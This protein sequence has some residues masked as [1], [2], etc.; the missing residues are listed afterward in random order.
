[1]RALAVILFFVILSGCVRFFADQDTA[2]FDQLSITGYSPV[3]GAIITNTNTVLTWDEVPGAVSYHFKMS[4]D[5]GYEIKSILPTP[6]IYLDSPSYTHPTPLENGISYSW[7]VRA[8]DADGITNNWSSFQSF[9]LQWAPENA[10]HQMSPGN[11]AAV[12]NSNLSFNWNPVNGAVQYEISISAGNTS[13]ADITDTPQYVP[14]SQ[15][16]GENSWKVRPI[17]KDGQPGAWSEIKQFEITW[18]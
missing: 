10:I 5:N 18:E 12:D 1:M 8:E 15:L 16:Y 3:S 13:I 2:S 9:F 6:I 14:T 17:D 11:D 7:T 4:S